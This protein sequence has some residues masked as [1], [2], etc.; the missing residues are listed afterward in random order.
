MHKHTTI[1]IITTTAIAQRACIDMRVNGH[2]GSAAV[3]VWRTFD[4]IGRRHVPPLPRPHCLPKRSQVLETRNQER[5]GVKQRAA[6]VAGIW[7]VGTRSE[8]AEGCADEQVRGVEV[9]S[10]DES[11]L[12]VALGRPDD[13][14]G[15]RYEG[16]KLVFQAF[17]LVV[18]AVTHART[19]QSE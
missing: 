1:I 8:S 6:V 5:S 15:V 17:N 18:I 9:A 10:A 4:C 7:T 16:A 3:G 19:Q 11:H 2:R 14:H 12:E 13:G